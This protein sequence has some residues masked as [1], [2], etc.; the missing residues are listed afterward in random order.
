ME[1]FEIIRKCKEKYD[2]L[3]NNFVRFYLMRQAFVRLVPYY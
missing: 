1:E 2:Q 3:S